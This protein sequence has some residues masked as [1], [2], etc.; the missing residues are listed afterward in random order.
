MPCP[1]K[2]QNA[3]KALPEPAQPLFLLPDLFAVRASELL[4][5]VLALLPLLPAGPL[6][7]RGHA[8][9]DLPVA[10]LKFLQCL[11]AVIDE[12]EASALAATVLRS[13]AEDTDGVLW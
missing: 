7:L 1:R 2:M 6:D 9:A 5:P 13:E 8:D 12:G 3:K 10:G 11:V 4:R